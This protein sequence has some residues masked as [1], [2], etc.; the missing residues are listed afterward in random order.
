MHA[1]QIIM[2][3]YTVFAITTVICFWLNSKANHNTNTTG[4]EVFFNILTS[5]AIQG[6]LYWGNFYG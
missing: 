6:V 2:I 4:A 1:P 5:L 3:G